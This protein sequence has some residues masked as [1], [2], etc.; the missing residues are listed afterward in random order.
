MADPPGNPATDDL[1]AP[2]R[3]DRGSSSG[4]PRWVT[5]SGA[6]AIVVVLLVVALMVFGGGRHGPGRHLPSGGLG[7]RPPAH[8]VVAEGAH[9]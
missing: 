3:R 8:S 7:G 6:I 4:T 1:G 5:V 2:G 9:G